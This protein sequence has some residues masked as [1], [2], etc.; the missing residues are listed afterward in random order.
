MA[1]FDFLKNLNERL[2]NLSTPYKGFIFAISSKPY[3]WDS[4]ESEGKSPNPTPLPH[5]QLLLL[6]GLGSKIPDCFQWK[7]WKHA[8]IAD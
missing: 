5:M 6:D 2:W 4:S 3:Y 7:V 1:I 8:I